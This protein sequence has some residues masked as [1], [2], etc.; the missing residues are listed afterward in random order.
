MVTDWILRLRSLF[1]RDLVDQELD[2]ELSAHLEHEADKLMRGGLKRTEAARQARLAL[3]G[4]DQVREAHRD[5][6]GIRLLDDLV[7]DVH[8]G[9]RQFRRSPGFTLL[10]ML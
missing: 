6:R 5:A 3:G 4:L 10:A 1:R 9:A 7:R 8:H 2:E